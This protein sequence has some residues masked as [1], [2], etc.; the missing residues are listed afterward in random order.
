MSAKPVS[1]HEAKTHLS[2]LIEKAEA[3]EEIVIARGK[4]PVVRLVAIRKAHVERRFGAMKGKARITPA[5][6]EALPDDEL[7]RW[8][9]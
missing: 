5:F 1:V 8:E 2:R 6:F 7:E 4:T 3:G 9:K